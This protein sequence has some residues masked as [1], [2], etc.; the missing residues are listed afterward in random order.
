MRGRNMAATQTKGAQDEDRLAEILSTR[1]SGSVGQ[2]FR[3]RAAQE[4]RRPSDLLRIVVEDW[5]EETG[6]DKAA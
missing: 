6:A 2:R 4:R 5:L 1:V 3:T